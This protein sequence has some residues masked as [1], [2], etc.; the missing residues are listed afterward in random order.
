MSLGLSVRDFLA[1]GQLIADIGSSLQEAGGSKSKN[2]EERPKKVPD[3]EI[4]IDFFKN[5]RLT[6]EIT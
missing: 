1:V 2:L 4:S 5:V 3:S 6:E